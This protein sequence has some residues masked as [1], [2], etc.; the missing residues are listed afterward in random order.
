[1]S[2]A[3]CKVAPCA[4]RRTVTEQVRPSERPKVCL[5]PQLSIEGL[6]CGCISAFVIICAKELH[7]KCKSNCVCSANVA[8][9]VC[10]AA[11]HWC[12]PSQPLQVERSPLDRMIRLVQRSAKIELERTCVDFGAYSC[13]HEL[14]GPSRMPGPAKQHPHSNTS[15]AAVCDRISGLCDCL[16]RG[17]CHRVQGMQSYTLP[18]TLSCFAM[19]GDGHQLH[20]G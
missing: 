12:T 11:R 3:N 2:W 10:I 19:A 9:R 8:A 17:H 1:M 16:F 13:L 18:P 4:T 15:S 20:I 5:C 14:L 6:I 7:L